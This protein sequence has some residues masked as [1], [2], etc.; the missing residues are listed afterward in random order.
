MGFESSLVKHPSRQ[1]RTELRY[2]SLGRV[3]VLLNTLLNFS[4][5]PIYGSATQARRLLSSGRL[6]ALCVGDDLLMRG[7]D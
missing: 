4:G 6:D 3:P 7:R 2:L 5:E 1:T